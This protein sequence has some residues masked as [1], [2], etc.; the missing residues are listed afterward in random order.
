MRKNRRMKK[1]NRLFRR[2]RKKN[3]ATTLKDIIDQGMRERE[4]DR[5]RILEGDEGPQL[6]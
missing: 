6:T 3:G 2:W 1:T 4:R 5:Q